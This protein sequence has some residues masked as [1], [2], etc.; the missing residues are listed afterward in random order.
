MT[1]VLLAS[2]LGVLRAAAIS[3]AAS[4][5]NI[6]TIVVDDWGWNDWGVHAAGNAASAEIQTP[7]MDALAAQGVILDRHYT[8]RFCSPSRSA[9]QTGRAPIHVNVLNDAIGD[10]NKKDPVSGFSG[11]PRNMTSI[12]EKLASVGYDTV[13]AGK[14]HA[15]LATPDHT[16]HGRFYSKSL[17][18]LS[19]AND[20][21]NDV[22]Y[23]ADG[24][25][26]GYC[27]IHQKYTDLW[28]DAA[29]A[30]GLNNSWACTQANQAPGCIYEDDL[31]ASYVLEQIAAHDV[32]SP[33]FLYYAPHSVHAPLEVPQAQL[34]K[35][36]FINDTY[37]R[38]YAAMVNYIDG[39]IGSVVAALQAKGIWNNTLLV[40]TS[41]NGGPIY[42]NGSSGGNNWPLRGGKMSN[43]EGGVRVNAFV[44]GGLI[45]ASRRG[46]VETGFIGIEDWYTTFCAL[47]GVD[48]ADSKAAA[49]GLPPVDG[50]NMWPLLSGQNST[51]PRTEVWLG[52]AF[53]FPGANTGDTIIQGLITSDGYKLIVGQLNENIWTGPLYPNTTTSWQDVPLSCGDPNPPYDAPGCLFN[54]LLDPTEHLELAKLQP[55]V[56]KRMAARMTEIQKSVFNPDRGSPT[57][58]ACIASDTVLHGFIGPFLP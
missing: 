11:I 24:V 52:A 17:A 37:R 5:P 48:P 43:W 42:A 9:F 44:S 18:Y 20:Y 55:D 54:V 49:A 56:V 21:F 33:L 7:N 28:Q 3:A 27:A 6:V 10:V 32:A 39:H 15:G 31:F 58:D 45:P 38:S 1:R 34:A 47:A 12:A 26:Q 22:V 14:W 51:S 29:P 23:D 16:P 57:L 4:A 46:Q 40:L 13:M 2:A 36:A 53:P 41:D 19:G 25:G 8:H 50:L 35:F 30:R